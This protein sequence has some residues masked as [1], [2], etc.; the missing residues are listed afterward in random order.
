M[1]RGGLGNA[2]LRLL[3]IRKSYELQVIRLLSIRMQ[4]KCSYPLSVVLVDLNCVASLLLPTQAWFREVV[5]RLM[6]TWP[7]GL[8]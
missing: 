2:W 6:F 8:L 5:G 1:R 3:W 7:T 4:K